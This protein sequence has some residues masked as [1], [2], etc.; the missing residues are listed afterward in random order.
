MDPTGLI[1]GGLALAA[2]G[3]LKGAIGAGAP[4]LAVPILA[5][6]YDVP[7]AIA[8]F[9]LPSL[10]SN[11]WQAWT[12]R[13]DQQSPRLVW[14]YASAGALGALLGSFLLVLLPGELLLATLATVVF[15]YIGIRLA[16]PDWQLARATGE[17][18]AFPVGLIGGMM[19]GAGGVSAPVSVT[20]L[21][22]MR[23][24]REDFIATISVFFASMSVVQIPTLWSLGVMTP[25][26]AALSALAVLPVFAGIPVGAWLARFMSREL[27]DRIILALLA[28]IALRLLWGAA[29]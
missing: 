10:F 7:L 24:G 6:L 13:H 18:F 21:N 14:T 17:R 28:V 8:I 12:F 19:Q 2:G 29:T 16:R 9:T 26:R 23:L 5:L 25:E 22:A 1:W 4:I 3:V 15:I 11:L 20:F 27:F